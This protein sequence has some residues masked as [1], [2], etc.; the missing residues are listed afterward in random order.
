MT[1][2]SL[3]THAG[4]YTNTN[5]LTYAGTLALS[6]LQTGTAQPNGSGAQYFALLR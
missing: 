4:T 2:S 3:F 6:S 1:L 5:G